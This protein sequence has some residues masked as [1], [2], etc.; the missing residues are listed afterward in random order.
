[1]RHECGHF[2]ARWDERLNGSWARRKFNLDRLVN[3]ISL[4][5][6]SVVFN[7]KVRQVFPRIDYLTNLPVSSAEYF[8]ATILMKC[9]LLVHRPLTKMYNACRCSRGNFISFF[10]SSS[11][12]HPFESS[13][14]KEARGDIFNIHVLPSASG[15]KELQRFSG[16]LF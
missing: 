13:V 4:N 16:I 9:K 7:I 3:R 6:V 1:M 2:E 11:L 14:C 15:H 12:F 10:S 5:S 8:S